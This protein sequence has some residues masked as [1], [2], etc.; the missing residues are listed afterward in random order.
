MEIS[1]GAIIYTIINKEINYLLIKDFHGNIGFPKG[2]LEKDETEIEAAIREIKEEVG[3]DII[4]DTNFRKELNYIM[5]NGIN[6][7]SVY[8]LGFYKDQKVIKQLEEVDETLLLP[9]SKAID[10]LTFGNMKEA[11]VEANNYIMLKFNV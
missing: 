5:P 9:F 8:Y 10:T 2:H 11:L 4:L 1:A 7:K 3:I 6:K